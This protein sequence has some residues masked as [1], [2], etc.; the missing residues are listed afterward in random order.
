[1]ATTNGSPMTY[2]VAVV[3]PQFC[4]PYSVN[5]TIVRK[6]MTLTEGNFAVTDVNG[7]ILYKFK[8]KLLSL[9]DRRILL[10]ASDKPI[11]SLQQ[12]I[13]SRHRRWKV[14][15]GDSS[16]E[17]DLLFSVKKSSILQFKTQ[18][19]VFLAS[20]HKEKT[21]DFK[22]KGSW[23]DRSCTIYA[24]DSSVIIAQM[25]KKQNVQS[26]V[27]GKD[28]FSVT[29]YPHVDHAFIVALV[30]ILDEINEDPVC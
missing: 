21:C 13:I 14:Y 9:R 27:L 8:G 28:T 12:K 7:N 17:K 20:N 1:M 3:H 10:D 16:E 2:P 15:K 5:L 4:A 19:D 26:V 18:L 11:V 24:R 25:H 29:V 22:I 30:V 6:V 23:L